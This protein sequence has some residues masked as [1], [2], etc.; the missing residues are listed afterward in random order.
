MQQVFYSNQPFILSNGQILPS[1]EITYRTY[2]KL[3]AQ[4]NNVVWVCHAL[5]ANSD[6]FEWWKGVAG[7]NAVIND[8][9]YFIICA[10]I[11]GS[12]YGSSGPLSINK[13]TNTPYYSGFPVVSIRDMVQAHILLKQHLGIQQIHLLM[14]GSMG[15]Y[16][17]LE[18]CVMEPALIKN[19]FLIA[20]AAQESAWGIAI[21]TA[22]RLAIE[23]DASWNT[24][25][26]NAGVKGL[27]AAR[28]IGMLT[29]RSYHIMVQ[30]Q[31]DDDDE[32]TDNYKA[33][34]YI[35]HQGDKLVQR[36][37][38]YSY[39]LLTKSMDAHNIAR[40]RNATVQQ[41]LQNIQ[42]KTLVMG[43]SNDL[44]CPPE[45]QRFLAAN[46]PAS[47]YIEIESAYGHD[48]FLVETAIIS[49]ALKTWLAKVI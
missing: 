16:Q 38:A 39:W 46:I 43:I 21:H 22:Q 37:N 42:Q 6:V 10:T 29:Y 17:A 28:A 12:C 41:V 20:T 9:E 44:L 7:T 26:A 3:N 49:N 25:Q 48:G 24:A 30:N 36:Y 2:G 13:L 19:V 18:W 11:I 31:T 47:T 27:K 45:E 32:K 15:G 33:S 4:K 34:S 35:N 5:T 8:H 14:G 40:G 23:A 1:L